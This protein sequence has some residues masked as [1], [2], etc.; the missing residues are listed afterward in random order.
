MAAPGREAA[1]NLAAFWLLGLLNNAGEEVTRDP[2]QQVA[3]AAHCPPPPPP[4]P[5][6]A[7]CRLT[8]APPLP[9]PPLWPQPAYVIMLAGANQISAAAVGLVYLAAVGPSLLC[10]AR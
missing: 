2:E 8:L 10:K 6:A 1:R 9:R 7:C 3:V 5:A 4:P